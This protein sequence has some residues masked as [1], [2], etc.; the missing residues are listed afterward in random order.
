MQAVNTPESP[1]QSSWQAYPAAY[2]AAEI[3]TLSK[4]IAVGASG[5]VVG[6]R[7]VGRSNLL[8]FLCHRPDVLRP[9]LAP[10]AVTVTLIPVDLGDLPSKRLA[11][12]YRV[13]LRSFYEMRHR[14]PEALQPVIAESYLGCQAQ[15]DPFLTQSALRQIL[16]AC[17]Q[18]GHRVVLV[19]DRFDAMCRMVTPDM[20]H[21]LGA[22]HDTFRDTLQYLV[23]IRHSLT[24]IEDLALDDDLYRLFTTHLYF[25]GPLSEVDARQS[26][27]RRTA[28]SAQ[29]PT[30]QEIQM[31]LAL[32][33]GYPTLVKAICRWWLLETDPPSLETWLQRLV[34]MPTIQ[35]RLHGIWSGLT[36][37]EQLTLTE[38]VKGNLDPLNAS[39][40][41][42]RHLTVL[43]GL[44]IKGICRQQGNQW[45]IFG[46]L[47]ADYVA[48]SGGMSR[49]RIWHD[50]ATDSLYFGPHPL[51]NLT[52]KEDAVL[53]FLVK[54][55]GV[56]HSY[57]D[58]IVNVWSDEESYHG[59]TND[60][61]FQVIKGLRRKI[62][63]NPAQP[64]YV[65]NW[66]GKPE[67]GYI[68]YP[69]GR[70]T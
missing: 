21:A 6:L 12:L 63:P 47:F 16:L 20:A 48:Q 56:R 10:F 11:D 33:G 69:E 42:Q 35:A 44:A 8:G 9:Y 52:P 70:P 24:Y 65:V 67:G 46:A 18:I 50:P 66:R 38:L 25:L 22:L 59:V 31:L 54:T 4:W 34:A 7:G 39:P 57:T 49:G 62:E 55:P 2:R 29:A 40:F 3:A 45:S 28:V 23:G 13:I 68:F 15:T 30:E 32:T 19:V 17:Q 51:G 60:S 36:Q 5:A 43:Q 14:F 27:A 41:Q 26:I 1:T 53:H 61:L 64:L 37:E 58:V